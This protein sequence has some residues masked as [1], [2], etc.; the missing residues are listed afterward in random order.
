MATSCNI[1]ITSDWK[2]FAAARCHYDGGLWGV[3][4]TLDAMYNDT[5]TILNLVALGDMSTL[6]VNVEATATDEGNVHRHSK[7]EVE[8][9]DATEVFRPTCGVKYIYV[10]CTV[11]EKWFVGTC[12]TSTPNWLPLTMAIDAHMMD[13]DEMSIFGEDY[14]SQSLSVAA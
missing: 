2:T 10:W 12:Y 5:D 3:G 14:T 11:Q 6:E 8:M 4:R 7:G 1:M 13:G 9:K